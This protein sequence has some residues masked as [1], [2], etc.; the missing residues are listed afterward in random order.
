MRY[1]RQHNKKKTSQFSW[2]HLVQRESSAPS[3]LKLCFSEV[4]ALPICLG[5]WR[6]YDFAFVATAARAN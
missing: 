3:N 4:F 1:L 2:S 5:L 6:H